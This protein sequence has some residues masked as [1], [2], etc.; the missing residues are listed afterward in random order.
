MKVYLK[1]EFL[2]L[3][4]LALACKLVVGKLVLSSF[5]P[6]VSCLEKV[7]TSIQVLHHHMLHFLNVH[8]T[9]KTNLVHL[10]T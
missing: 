1:N 8:P 5:F 6:P 3:L 7:K 9:S 10:V 2:T 4:L